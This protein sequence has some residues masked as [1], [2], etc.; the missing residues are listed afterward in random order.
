MET[1]SKM[2]IEVH[3]KYP[4]IRNG[5]RFWIV[6]KLVALAERI[7]KVEMKIQIGKSIK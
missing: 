1:P 2:S 5:V 4:K 3:V 6:R 7:G